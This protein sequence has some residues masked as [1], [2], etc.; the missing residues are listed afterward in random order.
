MSSRCSVQ[1]INSLLPC[2]TITI[3]KT[4]NIGLF[5]SW[6]PIYESRVVGISPGTGTRC[7]ALALYVHKYSLVGGCIQY[8]VIENCPVDRLALVEH[9]SNGA[10]MGGSS[11]IIKFMKLR[12]PSDVRGIYQYVLVRLLGPPGRALMLLFLFFFSARSPRSLGRSR[13]NFATWSE[14]GA[15]IKTKSKSWGPPQKKL[16]PKN[17]LF[18]AISD[19]FA[20]RSRMSP[21]WN[22]IS[23]I[24]KRRCKLRSLPRLLT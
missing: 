8:T 2:R 7:K 4:K 3:T 6:C 14:M 24:G 12:S 9:W 21:E 1:V 13:R 17:M 15:V 5:T 22:K 18:G 23:T 10:A 11:K 19:D 16:G 20:V